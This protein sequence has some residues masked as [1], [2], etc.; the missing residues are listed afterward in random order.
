M[1]NTE[2]LSRAQQYCVLTA[3]ERGL[4]RGRTVTLRSLAER[5]LATASPYRLTESGT[6]LRQQLGCPIEKNFTADYG[7]GPAAPCP[8]RGTALTRASTALFSHRADFG[9]PG[10]AAVWERVMPLRAAAVLLEA[11]GAQ[12]SATDEYGRRCRAGYSMSLSNL[13]G[14]V[15]IRHMVP[16][17]WTEIGHGERREENE[18][19]AVHAAAYQEYARL[20]ADAAWSA[21]VQF[22]SYTNRMYM[23]TVPAVA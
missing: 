4:L 13:S 12:P 14:G 9:R 23:I 3:D 16:H 2:R 18:I 1:A 17:Q 19:H 6:V 21:K 5:G 11:L 20:L 15:A 8:E 22:G 7:N 10:Q